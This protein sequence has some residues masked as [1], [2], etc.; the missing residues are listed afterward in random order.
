MYGTAFSYSLH[1]LFQIAK[2]NSNKQKQDDTAIGKLV[3]VM[4]PAV[5]NYTD[6]E[7]DKRLL[8]RDTVMK[9]TRSYGFVTQLVRINDQK[10]NRHQVYLLGS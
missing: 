8:F 5:D 6:L 10:Q 1:R 9:F 3:S 2:V 7:D 4:K